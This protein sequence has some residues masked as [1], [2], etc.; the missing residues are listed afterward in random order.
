MA[1]VEERFCWWRKMVVVGDGGGKW[2][3]W[4]G[5]GCLGGAGE[6]DRLSK[7]VVESLPGGVFGPN[8]VER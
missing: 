2:W 6:G 8:L 1:V 7:R 4:E 3:W 5:V